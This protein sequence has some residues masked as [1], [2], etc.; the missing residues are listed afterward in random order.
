MNS[1]VTK[2]GTVTCELG[3]LEEMNERQDGDEI[4]DQMQ[5]P[6]THPPQP[7]HHAIGRRRRERA[8]A[9]QRGE[10]DG[11]IDP[12]HNLARN[13]GKDEHLIGD[14]E[15]QMGD[16]VAEGADPDHAAHVHEL[17]KARDPPQRR[18]RERQQQ[19]HEHPEAGTVDQIIERASLE[20][21]SVCQ[22]TIASAIG[23][24]KSAS[25]A[26]RSADRRPR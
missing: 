17:A 13:R 20:L 14:V 18:D 3:L 8:E 9:Q 21:I 10:P 15:R 11:E 16:P 23:Q 5:P 19:E 1:P 2:V 24:S 25:V 22:A 26:M 4:D 6:P 7:A 12:Q